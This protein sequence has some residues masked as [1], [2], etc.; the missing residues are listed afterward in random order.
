MTELEVSRVPEVAA[1]ATA[2]ATLFNGLEIPQQRYAVRVAMD[3]STVSR[4]LNGRRVAT[5]E[6]VDRLLVELE[7]YKQVPITEETRIRIRRIRLEALKAT[8]PQAFELE[9]LRDKIDSSQR[10]IRQYR[11]Q[12]EALELLLDQK[13][14]AAHAA[15]RQLDQLRSDWVAERIQSE[16]SILE[17]SGQNMRHEEEQERLEGEICDLKEQIAQLSELQRKAEGRC[18]EL[19]EKLT[20][21]E[22]KLAESLENA[23]ERD[24]PFTHEEIASQVEGFYEEQRFNDAA[25]TLSLAAANFSDEEIVSLWKRVALLRRRSLDSVRL[26]DDA[27]RFASAEEAARITEMALKESG[28]S[29]WVNLIEML[30]ESLANSK[31][32]AELR[33]L[34]DRWCNAGTEYGVLMRALVSWSEYAPIGQVFEFLELLRSNKDSSIEVRMLHAAGRRPV[35]DVVK[36]AEMHLRVEL[37]DKARILSVRWHGTV[38]SWQAMSG[39]KEWR[40]AAARLKGGGNELASLVARGEGHWMP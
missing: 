26:L 37:L 29:G 22:T 35:V 1:L 36:L 14:S 38:P 15:N 4:Y 8:D 32:A 9:D 2:L 18:R 28:A 27:I 10:I 16:V 31:S 13:E 34:Y 20:R 40:R 7:R 25:R 39:E 17:L 24:F 21:A 23:R 3:K 33:V 12:Q 30:A 6:F 11:R 5:Q 19:E